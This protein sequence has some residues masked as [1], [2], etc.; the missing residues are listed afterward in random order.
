MINIYIKKK[1][2]ILLLRYSALSL[3]IANN[4]I[5]IV[6]KK[7]LI[8]A[9]G[10]TVAVTQSSAS[11]LD[12]LVH[13]GG[14]IIPVLTLIS[15]LSCFLTV[16]ITNNFGMLP[17]HHWFWN[18][19]F[20]FMFFYFPRSLARSSYLS[21]FRFSSSFTLWSPGTAPVVI[22]H[23]SNSLFIVSRFGLLA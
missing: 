5:Y 7:V 2:S 15:N 23:I 13:F 8:C 6:T 22:W 4:I 12:F 14:V 10:M 21:M 19:T 3:F 18:T 16:T 1:I 20:I 11:F 17:V 9:G